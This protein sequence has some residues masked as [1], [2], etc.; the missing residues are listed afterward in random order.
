MRVPLFA[1][2]ATAAG[3]TAAPALN[4]QSAPAE[5]CSSTMGGDACQK[6]VD[7]F[8]Y[9][10]FQLGTLLAGGNATLGQGG[11]LGGLGHFAIELRANAMQVGLPDI[12]KANPALQVGAAQRSTI[13]VNNKWAALPVVDAA[14]GLFKG[15]PLGI[16][17][18]GGVDALVSVAYLPE[19]AGSS[20]SVKAPDGRTK[21][22]YGARVGIISE[23][24][25][26][27][28]IS[29][30][31]LRR[32]LPRATI[33]AA[34]NAPESSV[35]GSVAV[36]NYDLQ[37]TAWRVVASKNL[38][39]VGL[40]AGIGQDKYSATAKATSNVAGLVSTTPVPVSVKPTRTNMFA[41]VSLNLTVLKIVAEVGRVSGGDV[42]TYNTFTKPAND[43]R[44]YGSLGVRLGL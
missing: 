34:V 23:S 42:V 27:P 26:T 30:T 9:M 41:D 25:V 22:G 8:N 19:F 20:V 39:I 5:G 6:A 28:G 32:D 40:A 12:P 13:P 31:W 2:L 16:T 43:P 7:L 29:V 15:I 37:T 36:E 11:T 3:L 4:A 18:V 21:W 14:V 17:S 1:V 38:L 24:M 10:N 33:T 44:F 35:P